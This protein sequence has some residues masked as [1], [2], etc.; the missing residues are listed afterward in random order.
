MRQIV[1][2]QSRCSPLP[3]DGYLQYPSNSCDFLGGIT[4]T[5]VDSKLGGK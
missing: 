5:M 2:A 3:E 4:Y 1:L